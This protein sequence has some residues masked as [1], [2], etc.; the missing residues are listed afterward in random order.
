[1]KNIEGSKNLPHQ[2][3]VHTFSGMVTVGSRI[4]RMAVSAQGE[5]TKGNGDV[6]HPSSVSA[7]SFRVKSHFASFRRHRANIQ[8]LKVHFIFLS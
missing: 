8:R 5:G 2:G 7:F 4:C 3:V 6:R 1:M